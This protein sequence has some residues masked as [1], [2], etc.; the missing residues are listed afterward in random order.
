MSL[1]KNNIVLYCIN[2]YSTN[3]VDHIYIYVMANYETE[4]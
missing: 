2:L 3:V 4:A 1:Y